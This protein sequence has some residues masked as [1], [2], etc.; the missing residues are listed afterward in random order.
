MGFRAQLPAQQLRQQRVAQGG[1]GA[2][3]FG[4]AVNDDLHIDLV[5]QHPKHRRD[6]FLLGD[7]G[8]AKAKSLICPLLMCGTAVPV[9]MA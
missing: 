2:G 8:D 4:V 3:L 5:V 6:G 9:V 1:E 7:G